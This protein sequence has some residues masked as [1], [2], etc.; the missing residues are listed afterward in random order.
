MLLLCFVLA[1]GCGG[2]EELPHPTE[3][4]TVLQPGVVVLPA[5]GSVTIS[6]ITPTS[7]TVQGTV[8]ELK[9]GSVVVSQEGAGLARRVLSVTSASAGTVCETESASLTDI[10]KEAHIRIQRPIRPS[11]VA[12]VDVIE[13]VEYV[14]PPSNRGGVEFGFKFAGT[15]PGF[16]ERAALTSSIDVKVSIDIG[17][18][19]DIEEGALLR[20]T[21][22]PTL[23]CVSSNELAAL[24]KLERKFPEEP[25]TYANLEITPIMF[26]VGPVP[27]M[28]GPKV[29]LAAQLVASLEGGAKI[30][31][32]QSGSLRAGATYDAVQ[33]VWTPIFEEQFSANVDPVTNAYIN[34]QA[35]LSVAKVGFALDIYNVA[36]PKLTLDIFKSGVQWEAQTN[37]DFSVKRSCSLAFALAGELEAKIFGSSGAS[38]SFGPGLEKKFNFWERTFAAGTGDIE[39]R[40]PGKVRP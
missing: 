32:E 40:T 24:G 2:R 17:I 29:T 20:F 7:M 33:N 35:S 5:D 12:R 23:G 10:F 25:A 9:S 8:P 30:K 16:H 37:P 28:I 27:V 6:D 22:A 34:A 19:V 21:V 31:L 26:M 11:D 39:I 3:E 18:S 36:G 15:F 14:P 4:R 13:G 38:Y 1:A